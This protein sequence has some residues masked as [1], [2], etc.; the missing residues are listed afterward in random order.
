M[1]RSTLWMCILSTCL[2]W[3]TAGCASKGYVD[4]Q[5]NQA[6]TSEIGRVRQNIDDVRQG[7]KKNRQEIDS[8]KTETRAQRE[9]LARKMNLIDEALERAQEAQILA[10]GKLLYEV[11][12]T[13]ES[14]HFGYKKSTLS[15]DAKAALDAFS[16]DLIADNEAVF[17]EIQ[18]HTD[19][20]GS[21]EYN[22]ELGQDRADSVRKY[23]N[24]HH[25]I[26][27]HRMSTISY[28]ES[29]PLEPNDTKSNRAQNRRVVLLVM[30]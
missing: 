1:K 16:Q 19:H 5:L 11:T 22:L 14:V 23:L 21:D 15:E 28:G 17:I 3:L 27:L 20:I 25:D 2:V 6:L 30:E 4:D 29:K 13:D 10:K 9:R 26:P 18:G 8:L 12:L 24:T 7:I